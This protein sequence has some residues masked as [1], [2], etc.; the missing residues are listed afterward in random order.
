MYHIIKGTSYNPFIIIETSSSSPSKEMARNVPIH[1]LNIRR[2]AL[3][4]DIE[5]V[6]FNN[7]RQAIEDAR[8]VD[9]RNIILLNYPLISYS[10]DANRLIKW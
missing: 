5:I 10:K 1:K 4:I 6:F 3:K 7:D 9:H 8:R 2:K